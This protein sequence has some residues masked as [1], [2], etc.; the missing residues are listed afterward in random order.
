MTELATPELKTFKGKSGRYT[1]IATRDSQ[2]LAF[3]LTFHSYHKKL[4]ELRFAVRSSDGTFGTYIYME[5]R[6]ASNYQS[7]T[8]DVFLGAR[9]SKMVLPLTDVPVT[10]YYAA[11]LCRD[12]QIFEKIAAFIS[13]LAQREGFT[14]LVP[15][16]KLIEVVDN[17]ITGAKMGSPV[18]ITFQLPELKRHQPKEAAVMGS[19][20]SYGN[21][22]TEG[23][24]SDDED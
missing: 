18:T 1:E 2:T 17:A 15:Q 3:S 10:A 12:N 21:E 7:D 5:Q 9:M 24:E 8:G 23:E 11:Q 6:A 19:F 14:V 20:H 4:L 13:D 16:E 22:E